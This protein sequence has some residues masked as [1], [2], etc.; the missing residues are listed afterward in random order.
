VDFF[1][2]VVDDPYT[3]GAISA[4]NAMSDVYA[5]GGEV[6]LALNV[7]AFPESLD[8][9]ILGAILQGGA[10][11]VR[12]AGGVIAGGH[13]IYDAEPKY[14][15]T[16][17]GI[18]HPQ[19]V[20]SKGGA[21]PGDAL[22]LTKPL[23]TG[24]VLTAIRDG[25]ETSGAGDLAIRSMLTLNRHASHLAREAGAHA[26]TDVTGYGLLGHASEIAARS[27]V[28]VVLNGRQAPAFSPAVIELVAGG[29]TTG[30]A[31]RNRRGLEGVVEIAASA[32]SEIV[33]LLYDPQTSGGLLI[34]LAPGRAEALVDQLRADGADGAA[35][36][37]YVEAGAG[38]RVI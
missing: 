1:P 20:L 29:V 4:A 27:G 17:T 5:M 31:A 21:Q 38:V 14:G 26:L 37:G 18:V 8:P 25:K 30:G 13:T 11:K 2:P 28:R 36:I 7:T 6:L 3:Y 9:A 12:E 16:V 35:V 23:G 24:V 34:A 19:Q 22:V 15:L 32:P 33:E 10:D